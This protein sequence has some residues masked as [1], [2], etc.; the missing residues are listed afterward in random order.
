M[1]K[2][3]KDDIFLDV[4]TLLPTCLSQGDETGMLSGT[5]Q[6]RRETFVWDVIWIVIP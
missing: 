3:L 2:V 5:Q 1:G 4:G 6:I